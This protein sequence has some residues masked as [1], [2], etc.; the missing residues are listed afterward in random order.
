MRAHLG[1]WTLV[2]AAGGQTSIHRGEKMSND[3]ILMTNQPRKLSG[4]MRK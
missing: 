3:E 1:F 2:S 4:S